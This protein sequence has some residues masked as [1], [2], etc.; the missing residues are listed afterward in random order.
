MFAMAIAAQSAKKD[1][2]ISLAAA[3]KEAA[4]ASG[5]SVDSI[6]SSPIETARVK[7]GGMDVKTTIAG[8]V[9]LSEI[10][11]LS[12]AGASSKVLATLTGR[13]EPITPAR[14]EALVANVEK[15]VRQM[16]MRGND[17]QKASTK[18]WRE[19][20]KEW[21]QGLLGDA[22]VSD[23]KKIAQDKMKADEPKAKAPKM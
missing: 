14:M 15:N 5:K 3:I 16:V 6:A 23:I 19:T 20:V 13:S 2:P 1:M 9:N 21:K 10:A 18:A 22:S 12:K 8:G 17:S 7:V 11:A 4:A